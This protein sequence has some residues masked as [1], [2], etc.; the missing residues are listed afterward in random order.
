MEAPFNDRMDRFEA[1]MERLR[2]RQEGFAQ[3]VELIR[4]MQADSER[5]IAEIL[6]AIQ[7]DAENIRALAR[8][9][10]MH[11]RRLSHLEGQE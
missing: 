7:Q 1:A 5:R 2:E 9:A 4:S 8:I 6:V 11:E 3:G 10:E